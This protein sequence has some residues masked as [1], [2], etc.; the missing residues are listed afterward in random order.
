MTLKIFNDTKN[1]HNT[2]LSKGK[3]HKN[4]YVLLS[5]NLGTQTHTPLI[6]SHFTCKMYHYTFDRKQNFLKCPK[7][8]QGLFLNGI[9]IDKLYILFISFKSKFSTLNT[10]A[11]LKFVY[12]KIFAKIFVLF[13]SARILGIT[14]SFDILDQFYLV[15][16]LALWIFISFLDKVKPT[17]QPRIFKLKSAPC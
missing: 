14:V 7:H 16:T 3:R 1:I 9:V 4:M 11:K 13:M 5:H 2:M 17:W 6:P 8:E 12:S 10:R 15:V